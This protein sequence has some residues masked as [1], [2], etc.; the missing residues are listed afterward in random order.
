MR[1]GVGELLYALVRRLE[2]LDEFLEA[3]LAVFA[4][5]D[6]LGRSAERDDVAVDGA[7]RMRGMIEGLLMYSRV[8]TRGDQFGPV[9]LDSVL[10]DVRADLRVR[11]Q[12][13]D[14]EIT[15]DSLPHVEGDESQLRQVFQN[16]LD[17]AIEY[18]GD[19]PP[20]IHVAAE[21]DGDWWRIDVSDEGVGIDPDDADRV[22]EV[23]ESL[24][25]NDEHPGT[26]IGLALCERIVERHG[27]DIWVESELGEGS[28]FSFTLPA[29]GDYSE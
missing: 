26:G 19:E 1:G 22:F 13:S 17:N 23:F 29:E 9:D 25:T 15:A 4:L 8:E 16:L 10:A 14:A 2:F 5:G 3:L 6:V 27:G 18:S 28:T 12:E 20:E 21:R 11:I 24:H 7:E